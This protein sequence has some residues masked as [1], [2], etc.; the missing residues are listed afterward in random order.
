MPTKL[1]DSHPQ[2]I[3]VLKKMSQTAVISSTFTKTVLVTNYFFRIRCEAAQALVTVGITSKPRRAIA[4]SACAVCDASTRLAWSISFVQTVPAI[5]LRAGRSESRPFHPYICSSAK[6]FQRLCGVFR[7]EGGS[8][9]LGSSNEA[10]KTIQSLLQ[11]ISH[12]RFDNGKTP[13]IV[14]QFL[15]DQLRYNDNTSNAVSYSSCLRT[16][17]ILIFDSS[18]MRSISVT[19][20]PLSLVLPSPRAHQSEGNLLP[21][22]SGL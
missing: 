10:L 16:T 15:I 2:A 22:T 20:F 3:T 13:P 5:L 1:Y 6:R 19:S 14:R 7:T 4:Y 17:Y 21:M 12:V 18:T 8:R 11:A 9:H